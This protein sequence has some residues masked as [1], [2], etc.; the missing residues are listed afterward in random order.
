MAAGGVTIAAW[1]SASQI[2]AFKFGLFP[3]PVKEYSPHEVIYDLTIATEHE[4]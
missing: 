4:K 3:V 2:S 1:R